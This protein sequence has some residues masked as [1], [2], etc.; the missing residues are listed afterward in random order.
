MIMEEQALFSGICQRILK[1]RYL[2]LI[3]LVQLTQ[4]SATSYLCG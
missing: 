1:K 2:E 3:G 4:K